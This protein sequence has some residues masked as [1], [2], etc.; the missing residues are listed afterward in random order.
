MA[1]LRFDDLPAS[2]MTSN[3]TAPRYVALSGES[4]V[5]ADDNLDALVRIVQELVSPADGLDVVVWRN[6]AVAAVVLAT[7]QTIILDGEHEQAWQ[8][9]AG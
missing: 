2:G 4:Y 1:T 3:E 6:D 8:R 9:P 7:G 5:E